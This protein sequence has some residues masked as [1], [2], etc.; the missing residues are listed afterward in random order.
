MTT[1]ITV[2][3]KI[4][5]ICQTYVKRLH[6]FTKPVQHIDDDMGEIALCILSAVNVGTLRDTDDLE[7]LCDLAVRSLDEIIDYQ[8][9]P[10]LAQNCLQE[11]DVV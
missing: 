1:Q 5:C 11:Q 7:D 4:E 8:K 10:V 3:L 2:R 9:Y 6:C